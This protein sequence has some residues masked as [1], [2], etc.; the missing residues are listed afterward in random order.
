MK[1][2]SRSSLYGQSLKMDNPSSFTQQPVTLLCIVQ[3]KRNPARGPQYV[4]AVYTALS[5]HLASGKFEEQVPLRSLAD[6]QNAWTGSCFVD[7]TSA[8][9]EGDETLTPALYIVDSALVAKFKG[10]YNLL[11]V[12]RPYVDLCTTCLALETSLRCNIFS[13][14]KDMNL[15]C[16]I[17]KKA[18]LL[19]CLV[20]IDLL[21][22]ACLHLL[23]GRFD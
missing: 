4:T 20:C 19:W 12:C 22:V 7:P 21:S 6:E 5:R 8:A 23:S 13:C 14:F 17:D 3:V 9:Q 2:E 1:A 11:K 18:T 16:R 15:G 10:V